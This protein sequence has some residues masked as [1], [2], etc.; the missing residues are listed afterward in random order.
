MRG[1]LAH[2]LPEPPTHY[3]PP[4]LPRRTVRGRTALFAGIAGIHLGLLA[5]AF[6]VV[7]RPETPPAPTALSVRMLAAEMPAPAEAPRPLP[8][9]PPSP[10]RLAPTRARPS[11]P[12]LTAAAPAAAA[13]FT[14]ALPPENRTQEAP[15]APAAVAAPLVAARFDADYLQNPKPAYPMVSRRLG[16]EGRVVLRVRVSVQGLP[17]EIDIK[18]SSGFARLDEAARSAV[19]KWRFVPA[20]RGDEALESS[21]LVPLTFKLET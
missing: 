14:V 18:Q 3:A 6:S 9:P 2:P 7:T 10:R 15:A 19:E 21:V 1:P 8:A 12:V 5:L 16:E 20:R 17:L 13:S 4:L 11:L